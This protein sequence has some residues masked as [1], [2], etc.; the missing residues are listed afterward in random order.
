MQTKPR[1]YFSRGLGWVYDTGPGGFMLVS[2]SWTGLR[3]MVESYLK[4]TEWNTK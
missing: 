3:R 1:A 4:G 2:A